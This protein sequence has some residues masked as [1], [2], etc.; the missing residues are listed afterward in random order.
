MKW[1]R[2]NLL[3]LLAIAAAATALRVPR[4][5]ERPMHTDEAVHAIKFGALLEDGFYRYDSHEFHGP[6]LNYLT[7]IPAW[8]SSAG[9][10]TEIDETTLRIVPVCFGVLVVLMVFVLTG[11]LG[12]PAVLVAALLTALSPAMVFY[13]R[14]YIQEMLMVCFTFAAV[15]SGYRYTLT[16][17]AIWAGATGVFLGLMHATKE[18][19]IIAYAA[20][21]LAI[22]LTYLPDR[23]LR[24][25]LRDWKDQIRPGHLVIAGAV[26]FVASA[27]FYSSF[28]SNAAGIV[29]SVTAYKTY[30][31]RAGHDNLHIHPWYYYLK[32]L[33]FSRYGSGP[34]WS[35]ALILFLALAGMLAAFKWSDRFECERALIRFVSFYSI[36]MTVAYSV[37][38][39]KTPWNL[40]EFLH[41][42]IL[43]AGVGAAA[44]IKYT[45]RKPRLFRILLGCVLTLGL[46]HL[47]G[48]AYL[49]NYEYFEDPVNPY[50]YAHP[51]SDTYQVV[52]RVEELA[53]V[54]PDAHNMQVEVIFPDSDYWPL[55]WYL[56]AF[57]NVGWWQEVDAKTLAAPVIIASPAVESD[58]MRKL[59][60]IPPPG[61][62]HLYVPLFDSHIALR[63]NIEIT[64]YV[65]NDLWNAYLQT[66]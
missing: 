6:T 53:T 47:A 57:P 52:S 2:E 62:R 50:V 26:M 31:S 13:S 20:M 42:L 59:Y 29:D 38:P 8:L 55:P 43:M 12:R 41:P 44:I 4:L 9:K 61:A 46:G 60:E 34:I 15:L 51:L 11:A 10:L 58:L 66:K 25:K 21:L 1:S 24:H 63:P 19:C 17:K 16:R 48:Q 18:T 65:R 36:L 30:L 23:D 14:Y 7:L 3:I 33:L 39:Y 35:E 37:I 22:L 27:L 5:Q 40:I 28:L 45:E 32:M 64:G 56:R 49:A 54:H